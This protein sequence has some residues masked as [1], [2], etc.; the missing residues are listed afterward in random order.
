MCFTTKREKQNE[1][2]IPTQSRHLLLKLQVL[3]QDKIPPDIWPMRTALPALP[4]PLMSHSRCLEKKSHPIS[5]P[6]LVGVEDDAGDPNLTDFDSEWPGSV[7]SIVQLIR[8]QGQTM[9]TSLSQSLDLDDYLLQ[10]VQNLGQ[11]RT[12]PDY[13]LVSVSFRLDNKLLTYH[14][15]QAGCSRTRYAIQCIALG[16]TRP[17]KSWTRTNYG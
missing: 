16:R 2:H 6:V 9:P 3:L 11:D 7:K 8:P 12:R 1:K 17:W 14:G 10:S 15:D 5:R 13:E 4:I